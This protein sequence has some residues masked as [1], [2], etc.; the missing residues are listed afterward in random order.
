MQADLDVRR[1]GVYSRAISVLD[2]TSAR[3]QAHST[4]TRPGQRNVLFL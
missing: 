2:R 3:A 4:S 1:I